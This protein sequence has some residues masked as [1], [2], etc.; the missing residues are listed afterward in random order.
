M[1]AAL[2][3]SAGSRH[4]GGGG[5]GADLYGLAA[6]ILGGGGPLAALGAPLFLGGGPGYGE[7]H[8]LLPGIPLGGLPG[9]GG[10]NRRGAAAPRRAA[11][12]PPIPPRHDFRVEVSP[13]LSTAR[14]ATCGNAIGEHTTRIG[15]RQAGATRRGGGGYQW[16]HLACLPAAHFREAAERGVEGLRSIPARDQ[17]YVRERM[18]PP[19]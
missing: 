1:V 10:G 8:D 18:R 15:M 7:P 11:P 5:G 14:C 16:H 3:S 17:A 12:A 13:Q 4:G 9:G 19:R 2:N 6:A